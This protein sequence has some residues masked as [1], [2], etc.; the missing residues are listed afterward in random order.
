MGPVLPWATCEVPCIIMTYTEEGRRAGLTLGY[1]C[2]SL[3][4]HDIYRGGEGEGLTLGYMCS[5][6]Y[7]HDI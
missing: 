4:Y 6:L 3:Y 5:S 7:Y 1:M 2:S